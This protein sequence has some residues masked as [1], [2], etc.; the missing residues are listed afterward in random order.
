MLAISER[1][2]SS[3]A[4][5]I[6][7]APTPAASSFLADATEPVKGD[8]AA[9]IGQRRSSP[10]YDVCVSALMMGEMLHE[11]GKTRHPAHSLPIS[12]RIAKPN[13][14]LPFSK[15]TTRYCVFSC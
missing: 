9:T 10:R 2:S 11:K 1:I 13:I 6:T 4:L 14:L 8:E 3:K 7:I 12:G 15:S 5:R